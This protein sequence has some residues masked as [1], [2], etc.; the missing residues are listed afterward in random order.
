MLCESVV[1]PFEK[2]NLLQM[3][4]R[5]VT[6][7][8]SLQRQYA[9]STPVIKIIEKKNTRNNNNKTSTIKLNGLC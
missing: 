2:S 4:T 9:I 7:F 8:M 6:D 1:L 3:R 5:K